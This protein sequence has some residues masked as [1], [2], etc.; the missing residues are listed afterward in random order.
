M[1]EKTVLCLMAGGYPNTAIQKHLLSVDGS[2]LFERIIAA[3]PTKNVWIVHS[4]NTQGFWN[5]WYAREVPKEFPDKAISFFLDKQNSNGEVNN[6]SLWMTS[7]VPSLLLNYQKE[8][9]IFSAI[10]TYFENF[11]FMDELLEKEHGVV[12]VRNRNGKWRFTDLFKT[13]TRN[14]LVSG[15]QPK[16]SMVDVVNRLMEK[17]TAFAQVKAKDDYTNI[18]TSEDLYEAQRLYTVE[19]KVIV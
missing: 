8:S 4:K 18:N 3:V 2:Y 16:G 9:V 19:N 7:G 5:G 15:Q 14:L 13:T 17:G 1:S 6:P 10:D 12:D 11:N